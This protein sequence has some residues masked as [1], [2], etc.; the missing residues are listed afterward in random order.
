MTKVVVFT[1]LDGT[2]LDHHT[3]SWAAAADMLAQL[4]E[5]GIPVV[6]C[7]SKTRA[8]LLPLRRELNLDTP[9]I[10]ENGAAVLIPEAMHDGGDEPLIYRDGFWVQ[11]LVS[12]RQEWLALVEA[13]YADGGKV[14]RGFSEMSD[15]EIA[16]ATG[17]S[18]PM[19]ARA[20]AREYGE[21]LQW[22]VAPE[23]RVT[24]RDY[25]EHHGGVILQG[26]RFAHVSG[27]SDKGRALRW[28]QDFFHQR[29]GER[30]VSIA[31]GDSHNDIA[32][33][34]S[35]DWA[36]LVRSPSHRPPEL[37]RTAQVLVSDA[38]GPAGWSEGLARI[39]AT[40]GG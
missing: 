4:R 35:A 22:L 30:P 24:F 13:A 11:E 12:P 7:T 20:A 19:A 37:D 36:L 3:Y 33:L 25:I 14:A 16:A 27:S 2:L 15:E 34:E 17:L 28:L 10:V 18:I 32:M 31:A 21:P 38:I 23:D 1:D 9:F 6:P 40:I 8:E 29:W 5:A 26:G 39:L